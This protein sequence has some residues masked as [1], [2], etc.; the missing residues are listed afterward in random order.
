MQKW[1]REGV[2]L[3]RTGFRDQEISERHRFWGF[4]CPAVDIDFLMLEF[5]RGQPIA[6]IEYKRFTAQE[7]NPKHPSYRALS[8]LA[9]GYAGYSM[10]IDEHGPLP[11]LIAFYWPKIWAFRIKLLNDAASACFDDG[12]MLTERAYVKRLYWMRRTECPA[13]LVAGLCDRLP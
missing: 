3:E 12:E 7:P 13:P 11:C 1:S 8:T 10:A 4:D 9:D 6:I 2:R 5:N